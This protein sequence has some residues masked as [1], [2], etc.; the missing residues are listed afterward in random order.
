MA[1]GQEWRSWIR[2]LGLGLWGMVLL[3]GIAL[4]TGGCDR[5][6]IRSKTLPMSIPLPTGLPVSVLG[7]IA[8]TLSTAKYRPPRVVWY[9]VIANKLLSRNTAS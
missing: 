4:G 8:A 2:R 9:A 3:W 6:P 5:Y 7:A 1:L